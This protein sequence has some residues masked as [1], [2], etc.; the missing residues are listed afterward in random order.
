MTRKVSFAGAYGI[1]SQGDDAALIVMVEGLRRRIGAFDG[2]VISRHA[3]DNSYGTYGLRSVQNIEYN[4]KSESIGKWFRGFNY[5]DDRSHLELLREEIGSSDLLVLGAGN[6]LVDATIDLL[7]GPIPYLMILT[8]MAKM[9]ETPVMWFGLSIGPF[10][11]DYGQRLSRLAASLTDFITVR[12]D[13]SRIELQQFGFS[14]SFAQ[15]PDPVLGLLPSHNRAIPANASWQEAHGRSKM[16]I[17]VSVRNMSP[18]SVLETKQYVKD[19]ASICDT[20]ISQHDVALLFVPHCSYQHGNRDEDDRN[21]AHWVVEQMRSPDNAIVATENLT[22]EQ[23]LSLYSRAEVSLCTRLH[24][25]VYSAIQGV[26]PVAIAYDPKVTGF[27]HWLGHNE[28]VVPLAD[29]SPEKV[30]EKVEIA[31][32][33]RDEFSNAILDRVAAGRAEVDRY[34]DIA[35]ELIAKRGRLA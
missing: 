23:C 14:G 33:R 22:I 17:A 29:F 19:V 2:V 27:M 11:T 30:M 18:D 1:C 6:F 15:L 16:V 20:L 7:R 4:N 10:R 21:V 5:D 13:R 35:C 12:D 26:P 25:S 8:L 34:A 28:L 24:A 3:P 32:S 31:L 9:S